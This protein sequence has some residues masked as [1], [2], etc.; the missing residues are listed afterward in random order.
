VTMLAFALAGWWLLRIFLKD[1]YRSGAIVSLFLILFFSYG[2][3]RTSFAD[4]NMDYILLAVWLI[5]LV[6]T[7]F[8]IVKAGGAFINGTKILNIFSLVLLS[9]VLVN[10]GIFHLEP[11]T[12]DHGYFADDISQ[13]K[14]GK[15]GY[16]SQPDIYFV[17]LDAYAREDVLRD[18]YD[19]DNSDFLGFLESNDFYIAD[20]AISNYGQTL[21]SI[22]SSLNFHYLDEWVARIGDEN[23]RRGAL[24]NIITESQVIGFLR[25]NGYKIIVV[26]PTTNESDIANADIFVTSDISVNNVHAG[27][28]NTTPLPEIS[29]SERAQDIFKQYRKQINFMFDDLG[30]V[31]SE[32]QGPKFVYARIKVPHPPFVFDSEGDTVQLESRF[33]D[34]DGDSLIRP[35]KLSTQQ[36][37][38]HYRN[39]LIFTNKRMEEVISKI[40]K[41][42]EQPPIMLVSSDHGPRSGLIWESAEKTNVKESQSILSAYHLPGH[43]SELLYPGIS[44]VNSFRVIFNQYFGTDLELLP[45]RSYFSTAKYLYKF[46]DVTDRVN[47]P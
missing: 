15:D 13:M 34:L 17:V 4:E 26:A 8:A 42:S 18:V 2:H 7:S 39:Q 6:S 25:K 16:A 46:Q 43:G 27:L 36:Y 3:V 12:N 22:G 10:I 30:N 35:G 44:P 41:D 37:L 33:S 47:S 9:L 20:K 32:Y 14:I 40:L 5:F 29:L 19:F 21:L 38:E 1:W 45:D 24:Y 28:R 23:Q 31:S 11:G